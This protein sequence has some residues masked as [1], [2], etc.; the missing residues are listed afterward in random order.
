MISRANTT[1]LSNMPAIS[2]EVI[3]PN[4]T[5][6]EDVRELTA[7]S[8]QDEQWKVTKFE[9]TPP[10]STYLA[11]VANGEFAFLETSVKMP[12]SGKTI[13]LRIYGESCVISCHCRPN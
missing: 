1:N 8:K 9:N 12:L 6:S 7:L 11:A 3:G 5:L 13:P 10:M 4:S 2:E